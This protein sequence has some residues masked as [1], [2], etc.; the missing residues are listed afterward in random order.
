MESNAF[1][2]QGHKKLFTVTFEQLNII[3][4]KINFKFNAVLL[5]FL[6]NR[7]TGNVF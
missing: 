6:I 1:I 5:N 3:L 2:H 4:K 7:D